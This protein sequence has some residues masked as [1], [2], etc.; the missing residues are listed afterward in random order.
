VPP[1]PKRAPRPVTSKT[2]GRAHRAAAPRSV[3]DHEQLV[4]VYTEVGGQETLQRVVTAISRLGRRLDVF[5]RQQFD[6]LNISH[7]EWTV[8]STL[9]VEDHGEG[10]TPTKLADICGVS[11]STMT[12]RLDRMTERGLLARTPDSENRTRIR[13]RLADGGWALFKQAVLDA[14]VVE[15]RILSPLTREE[16][17]QL[18]NLLE[19]VVTGLRSH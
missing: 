2:S 15:T 14:E 3:A 6:E 18:A 10:S 11:P 1:P 8:L 12:H 5:Y 13:V 17:R 9:A 16:R 19:K 7:G 4:A